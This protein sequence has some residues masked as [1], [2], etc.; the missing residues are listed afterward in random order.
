MSATVRGISGSCWRDSAPE[1]GLVVRSN[2]ARKRRVAVGKGREL[3]KHMQSL[4]PCATETLQLTDRGGRQARKGRKAKLQ[5]RVAKVRLPPPAK[6]RDREPLSM[7]AVRATEADPPAGKRRL[8]WLLLCSEGEADAQSAK[9]ILRW[10]RCRWVVEEFFRVLKTGTR[11]ERRMFDAADDL[12]KCLAF[13]AVTAWRVFT[14]ERAARDTP[15]R[16]ATDFVSKDD[17]FIL[18]L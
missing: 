14:L 13:D 12:D 17:I 1:V 11:I 18:Y 4:A 2:R 15:T 7:V 8:D 6:C 9:R 3:W 10:Y 5:I 16:A